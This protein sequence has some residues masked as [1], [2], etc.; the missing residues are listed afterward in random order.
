MLRVE[1]RCF[2]DFNVVVQ[3]EYYPPSASTEVDND[4]QCPSP[5]EHDQPDEEAV[6]NI[7]WPG[8]KEQPDQKRISETLAEWGYY[9]HS[10]KPQK[11]WVNQCKVVS[12]LFSF[13]NIHPRLPDITDPKHIVINISEAGCEK[14]LSTPSLIPRL[15]THSQY[16]V[17]RIYP[18][19]WRIDSSNYD[20]LQFWRSGS[21]IASLNWQVFDHGM[22]LNE[23]MFVGSE[24]WV[25]KPSNLRGGAPNER[26]P[27]RFEMEIAGMCSC[28][29]DPHLGTEET[30]T[31]SMINS[32]AS[33]GEEKRVFLYSHP[34]KVILFWRRHGMALPVG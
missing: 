22:Q 21:H 16:Y 7:L 9:A 34:C 23:A 27:V 11:E 29:F 12:R 13:L 14:V 5:E 8:H 25:V 1:I 20:P 26:R 32:A 2:A 30:N 33:S 31:D 10:M 28:Q 24:G 3:V 6:L 4:R 15:I 19:G 17:R 18:N